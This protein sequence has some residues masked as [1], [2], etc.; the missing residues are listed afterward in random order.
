MINKYIGYYL[1][2]KFKLYN[3][4]RLIDLNLI[5]TNIKYIEPLRKCIKLK[6]LRISN[7]SNNSLNIISTLHNL[8]YLDIYNSNNLFTV[9]LS[10]LKY[11][12]I[13]ILSLYDI[14]ILDITPLIQCY[15]LHKLYLHNVKV[16]NYNISIEQ[17]YLLSSYNIKV[18]HNI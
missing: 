1:T 8:Q 17:I 15:N 9:N 18:L 6:T 14:N 13:E 2:K 16:N 7:I 3:C 4:I 12:K 10:F 5:N 11:T